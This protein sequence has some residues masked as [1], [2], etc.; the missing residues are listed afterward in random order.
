[1]YIAKIWYETNKGLDLVMKYCT[2]NMKAKTE[3][4][5]KRD[6]FRIL[7]NGM[8]YEDTWIP[9]SRIVSIRIQEVSDGKRI[10]QEQDI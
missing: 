8:H 3:D 10:R 5:K 2:L 6:I 4:E 1:M 7:R 9:P